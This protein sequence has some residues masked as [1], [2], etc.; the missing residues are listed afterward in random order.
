M[1]TLA[2]NTPRPVEGGENSDYPIVAADI[3]WDGSGIGL[4]DASGHARPLTSADKFVGFEITKR[5]NSDGAAAALNGHLI[6]KG[7]V[8][9]PITDAVITDVRLPVY[10]QDDNAFSFIKT[11]GVFIGY[12]SRYHAAGYGV[13]EFD[14]CGFQDPWEGWTAETL[15]VNKT[16]DVE[17]T[18][19]IF[20]VTTDAVVV[21]VPATTTGIHCVIVNVAAFGVALISVSPV[22]ADK[23]M[24]PDIGGTD[25]KDLQNTKATARRGDYV[26]LIDGHADG[27]TIRR[28][29]G[30]WV[31]ES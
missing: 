24:G 28:I 8:V 22:T 9:L 2:L 10:A 21:S 23:I 27:Y 26:E 12:M 3:L 4:V 5:D 29:S 7:A 18:G 1:T 14:A 31:T 19:K 17:D 30:T 13:V 6:K 20:F 25:A 16:L 11:S 15:A